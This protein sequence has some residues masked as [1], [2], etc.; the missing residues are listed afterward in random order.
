MP[1]Q[2]FII[3]TADTDSK[4][5]GLRD[6]WCRVFGD[7]PG[8][9]DYVYSLFGEDI[10]GYVICND[11]RKVVSAL[12]RY[13]CGDLDGTPVYVSYAVCTDPEYRGLGL[14]GRLTGYVRSVVTGARGS[15][16]SIEGAPQ[17]EGLGSI[18]LVSPAEDSLIGFYRD[19]GYGQSCFADVISICPG[20]DDEAEE[21]ILGE[22][23]DFDAF[24]PEFR[25]KSAAASE[26]NM[27]REA[28][29]R[30]KAHV[31]MSGP[32]LDLI[33]AESLEGNGLLVINGG[34][35]ICAVSACEEGILTAAEYIVN[36][37]LSA[38]SEEIHFELAEQL[39]AYYGAD[40]F[41]ARMPALT[42]TGKRRLQ[43]MAAGSRDNPEFYFGFPID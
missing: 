27:Y 31:S 6:L 35:A 14:G 33:R 9:V 22:D 23:D 7:E 20:D 2:K 19:L 15:M 29:L 38:F 8:Y 36:P 17:T 30:D 11:E 32:M 24:E 13:R 34:D 18:S 37:M 39:A 3:E 10:T 21:F 26:Y 5:E 25:V 43:S 41:A 1:I 28:F 40:K 4:Y 16:I 42:L 12:T